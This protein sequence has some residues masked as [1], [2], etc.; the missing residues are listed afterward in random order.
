MHY[1]TPQRALR[2]QARYFAVH[3]SVQS[4]VPLGLG[5]LLGTR[6]EVFL[7]PCRYEDIKGKVDLMVRAVL[8][9]YT[10]CSIGRARH[11][12]ERRVA[13][14]EPRHRCGESCTPQP[15]GG[16]GGRERGRGSDLRV[17]YQC[18]PDRK[19]DVYPYRS[20]PVRNVLG[21]GNTRKRPRSFC[22]KRR[23]QVTP[24][25]ANTLG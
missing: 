13:R 23:W 11:G 8:L 14:I 4:N 17:L 24:K 3:Q 9:R 19:T 20:V 10:C 25:H 18:V 16:G 21:L 2:L 6:H 22:Q 5:S 15:R 1:A 12:I 7:S